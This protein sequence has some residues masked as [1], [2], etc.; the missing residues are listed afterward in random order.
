MTLNSTKKDADINS[1]FAVW[2]ESDSWR[3]FM[4]QNNIRYVLCT[5]YDLP[6][7]KLNDRFPSLRIVYH[8]TAATVFRYDP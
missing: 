2:V 8:N 5:Q 7:D 1:F 6:P 4:K 3:E